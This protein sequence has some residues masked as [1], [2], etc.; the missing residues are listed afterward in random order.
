MKIRRK[1][2]KGSVQGVDGVP[3]LHLLITCTY[4]KLF[5]KDALS[6][7]DHHGGALGAS[8]N[9]AHGTSDV[10][11]HKPHGTSWSHLGGRVARVSQRASEPAS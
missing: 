4:Q 7:V 2:E 3:P 10:A 1:S 6:L 5:K 9:G 11:R 8:S